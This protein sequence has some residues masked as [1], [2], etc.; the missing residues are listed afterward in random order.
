MTLYN[1]R[2]LWF[3]NGIVAKGYKLTK[4]NKIVKDVK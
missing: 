3:Y 4:D 1:A 2:Q